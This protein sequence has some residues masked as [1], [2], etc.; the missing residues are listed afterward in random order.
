MMEGLEAIQ[1]SLETDLLSNT[2]DAVQLPSVVYQESPSEEAEE[3]EVD[4]E[5]TNAESLENDPALT[6]AFTEALLLTE[7]FKDVQGCG[8]GSL[9]GNQGVNPEYVCPNTEQPEA[10]NTSWPSLGLDSSGNQPSSEQPKQPVKSLSESSL[11]SLATIEDSP[12]PTTPVQLGYHDFDPSLFFIRSTSP[13]NF[14]HDI[15]KD[16]MEVSVSPSL[17]K[18]DDAYLLSTHSFDYPDDVDV[19]V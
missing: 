17:D 12:A 15:L 11:D 13:M 14:D 1:M 18:D 3:A 16:F 2:F 5:L 10:E 6:A 19:V 8:T 7:M 4:L 9:A